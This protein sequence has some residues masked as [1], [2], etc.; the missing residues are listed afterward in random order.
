MT[1]SKILTDCV[2]MKWFETEIRTY[3]GE[4]PMQVWHEYIKWTEQ[5]F[6]KGGRDSNLP[7]LLERCVSHFVKDVGKYAN[8]ARYVEAWI[9]FANFCSDPIEIYQF[10]QNKGIGWKLAIFYESLANEYENVG[11]TKKADNVYEEGIRRNAEPKEKLQRLHRE[12][13]CRVAR[14][15][16]AGIAEEEPM[17]AEIS[18]GQRRAL[19]G[20]KMH[21]KRA[22]KVPVV[23]VGSQVQTKSRGLP[24]TTAVLQ[25]SNSAPV[26]VY[27][28]EDGACSNALLPATGEWTQLAPRVEV[29]KENTQTAGKWN[30]CKIPQR[31][32]VSIGINDVDMPAFS[33]HEDPEQ[34]V[35]VQQPY[36]LTDFL[37]SLHIFTHKNKV[38]RYL[39]SW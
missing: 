28:D 21:G 23:R 15:A 9:K 33:V 1:M 36:I 3:S 18:Q 20:L 24:G 7:L 39:Q 4:D 37:N 8:D 29:A 6:P 11:N 31:G 2:L 10:I 19:G 34:L 38:C 27:G 25:Q 30:K 35:Y 13:K 14:E 32:G 12:F 17:D 16:A 22:P 5:N 26:K